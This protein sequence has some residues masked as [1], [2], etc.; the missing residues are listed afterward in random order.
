MVPDGGT[1][2]SSEAR[3]FSA[4]EEGMRYTKADA[5]IAKN[6][7]QMILISFYLKLLF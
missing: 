4:G 7:A 2:F 3:E 1:H 5:L 6:L